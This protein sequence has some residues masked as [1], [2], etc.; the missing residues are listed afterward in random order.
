ME[1]QNPEENVGS[2]PEN[3][4]SAA[5]KR[6][7]KHFIDNCTL[8]GLQHATNGQTKV[9]SIIWSAF[10]L[11]GT[12]YFVHQSYLL[13]DR[14]YSYPITTKVTLEYEE[15]P[16]FPAV[17][18]CNFN[19]L[20]KSYIIKVKAEDLLELAFRGLLGTKPNISAI[21]WSNSTIIK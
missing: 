5:K 1:N 13:L 6:K 17:T 2:N 12:A 9:R 19:V 7:W 16:E 18:I 20:R 21:D 11:M 10:L 4:K 8:H 15:E 3:L 14:Y